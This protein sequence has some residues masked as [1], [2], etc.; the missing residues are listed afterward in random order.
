MKKALKR[1]RVDFRAGLSRRVGAF[2][3]RRNI[4]REGEKA[5][6]AVSGG[7][8]STA[9]LLLL[10]DLKDD[11]G[12][13]LVVAHF[14]HML[15]TREEAKADAAFVRKM[16]SSLGLEVV[17]GRGDVPAR[18][19]EQGESVE[20]S[21]RILR[22]AY[23]G[24][25]A[26][27]LGAEV[28]TIGHSRDD[29]AETVLMHMA[30]GSG[31]DGLAGMRPRSGW[32][33]GEGPELARPLLKITRRETERFCRESGIIPREDPTN[34]LL[35]ATR[36]RIRHELLPSLR[37]FN[38]RIEDALSRLA[39]A[40]AR[41]LEFLDAEAERE[42]GKLALQMEGRISFARPELNNLHPAIVLRL[43]KRAANTLVGGQSDIEALHLGDVLGLLRRKRGEASLPGGLT[44]V[45]DSRS[46]SLLRGRP[47]RAPG[48][49]ETELNIPG[50]TL[51]DGW[52]VEAEIAPAQ[53]GAL[54]PRDRLEAFL[55]LGGQKKLQDVLVD[56]KTPVEE[57][58]RIP[59]VC[60][61]WG[62][63]WVVGY[64]LDERASVRP[65][66]KE[67]LRLRFREM[68]T[69]EDVTGQG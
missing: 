45:L 33:F 30:R 68:G 55:G 25:Q 46:L 60:A 15:R 62:I 37:E 17:Y 53:G 35:T 22:Y 4:F 27:E 13:R 31:L 12:I 6:V 24:E 69:Q 7:A 41:D 47:K 42:W 61:E 32:P 58:D 10:S 34:L 23:L 52:E 66:A 59:L 43:V 51:F 39:E 5:L 38:P 63:A 11:L 14:D 8:D 54:G 50:R 3:R 26:R 16:S 64:C 2:I 21:A 20:E 48:I 18:A 19:R 9:L 57:R 29:Q 36:N 67:A 65:G 49:S 1:P 44:A 56:A 40:A 28:V